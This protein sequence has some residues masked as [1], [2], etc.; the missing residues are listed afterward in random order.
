MLSQG[1]RSNISA[2]RPHPIQDLPALCHL[3]EL[4]QFRVGI[5]VP[6]YDPPINVDSMVWK[7]ECAVRR[8]FHVEIAVV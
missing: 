8:F 5:G 6:M 2:T 7:I 4:L 1:F 3:Q